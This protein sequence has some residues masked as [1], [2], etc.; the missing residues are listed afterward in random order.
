MA[1]D[2]TEFEFPDEKEVNPVIKA[3]PEDEFDIEIEDDTPEA[4]RN[5]APLD[6]KTVK[7]LEEDPLEDYSEKVKRRLTEMKRVWHDERREK[8]AAAREREEAIRIA[9]QLADENKR[10][11]GSLS[12]GEKAYVDTLT[13][14]VEREMEMAKREYREAYDS[15][16]AEKL[17]DAQQKLTDVQMRLN[18]A[19]NYRTQYQTP[20][21]E[22]ETP[23]EIAAQPQVPRPDS[24]ALSW[25]DRNKWFGQDEEMT[26]L[27]LGLHEKLVKTG[28]SPAAKPDE[29]YKRIDETMRKRFPEYFEDATLEEDASTQ[30]KADNV[31]APATRST[32]PKRVVL[33][34]TQLALAKKL[35]LT[36]KQYAIE[37]MK[38]EKQ[39]G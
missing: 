19:K 38:L 14:S 26:S 6:A 7:E 18:Q 11:K 35:G 21:Q 15:G 27:A 28:I 2:Q 22:E 10:L 13:S 16:D 3:K 37:A 30:R 31:V 1:L 17:V 24:R 39:N 34:K 20:L 36:P 23:V 8:E 32:A 25:Q 33:N 4:D 9:K 5:R 29:Y 12:Y